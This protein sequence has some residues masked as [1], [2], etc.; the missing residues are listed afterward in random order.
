MLL[1]GSMTDAVAVVVIGMTCRGGASS[2]KLE[3]TEGSAEGTHIA[4]M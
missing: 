3:G 4:I 1:A 2:L